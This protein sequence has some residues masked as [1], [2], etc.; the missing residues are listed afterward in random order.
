MT[1]KLAHFTK[2]DTLFCH[3]L[4]EKKL[5]ASNVIEMNDPLENKWQ[6]INFVP[7]RRKTIEHDAVTHEIETEY[8]KHYL[9]NSNRLGHHI[10]IACF[11]SYNH[12]LIKKMQFSPPHENLKMWSQYGDNH[13]GACIVINKEILLCN[14]KNSSESFL[15]N[16]EVLYDN[17]INSAPN[18]L[19]HT[20]SDWNKELESIDSFFHRNVV[21][22]IRE[23][24]TTLFHK[25]IDWR[26]E[27]EERFIFYEK[28]ATYSFFSIEKAI[29][30]LIF[31]LHTPQEYI[32]SINIKYPDLKLSKMQIDRSSHIK[33]ENIKPIST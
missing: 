7:H 2:I 25:R 20:M 15:K 33:I 17:N 22:R 29:D 11:S 27:L 18:F 3:I 12:H 4:P 19:T 21:T 14:I 23:N 31:G 5:R 13:K 26:D 28:D 10:N 9:N 1:N 32:Q 8:Y 16:M 24:P 30:E 6:W